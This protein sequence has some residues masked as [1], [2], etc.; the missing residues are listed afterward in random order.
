MAQHLTVEQREHA[1][2]LR[3]GGM[4]IREIAKE[5]SCSARTVKRV[6]RCR[7]K[8]EQTLLWL[9]RPSR[10]SLADREEISLGLGRSESFTVI[11]TRLS[12]S[13]GPGERSLQTVVG[14]VD[15]TRPAVE[16]H[17]ATQPGPP[18]RPNQRHLAPESGRDRLG[19]AHDV[20]GPPVSSFTC[21]FGE[22]AMRG[23]AVLHDV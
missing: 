19:I 12:R 14:G 16:K 11:A 7:G 13:N 23:L 3:R 6:V 18:L 2:R 22:F 15:E 4:G 17:P 5:I 20:D 1:R 10:L 9:P 21:R 8:R